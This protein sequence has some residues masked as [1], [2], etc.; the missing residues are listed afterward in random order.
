MSTLNPS[1][2]Y[3]RAS[4]S[5]VQ[6]LIS[7][8][9][10]RCPALSERATKAGLILIS[11]RVRPLDGCRYEVDGSDAQPYAVDLAGQTCSCPDFQHRA[12]A[13]PGGD[14]RI[15]KHVL[16][17]AFFATLNERERNG[18]VRVRAYTRRQPSRT[19][20]QAETASARQGE[21]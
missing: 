7:S 21:S 1:E 15:C 16:G 8:I 13:W 14:S 18:G 9:A 10:D 11:G 3:T 5:Q 6:A 12:P 17:A 4:L 2:F 20:R 19:G